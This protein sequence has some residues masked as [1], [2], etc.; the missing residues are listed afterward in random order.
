MQSLLFCVR[1][2]AD[3]DFGVKPKKEPRRTNTEADSNIRHPHTQDVV[4]VRQTRIGIFLESSAGSGVRSGRFG[5]DWF[6]SVRFG[7][8]R[9]G[10]VGSVRFGSLPPRFDV[11]LIFISS[12]ESASAFTACHRMACVEY[13]LRHCRPGP[14]LSSGR[15]ESPPRTQSWCSTGTA[16]CGSPLKNKRGRGER[17][18]HNERWRAGAGTAPL[19]SQLLPTRTE[20]PPRPPR[21]FGLVRYLSSD[22]LS[23]P[24]PRATWALKTTRSSSTP[25]TTLHAQSHSK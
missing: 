25:R 5:S 17:S 19:G 15:P 23:D 6:G 2:E 7:S 13:Y 14:Q 22:L 1:C 12:W 4:G 18:E 8:V 11:D 9:F 16:P 21:L 3:F 10:S 24:G 20:R